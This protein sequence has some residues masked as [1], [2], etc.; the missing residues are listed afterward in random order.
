MGDLIGPVSVALGNLGTRGRD[1][2]K[3]EKK[4]GIKKISFVLYI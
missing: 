4:R 2:N 1:K 3:D